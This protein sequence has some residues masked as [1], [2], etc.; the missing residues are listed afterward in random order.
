MPLRYEG[1]DI[2]CEP[3]FCIEKHQVSRVES[4]TWDY[5]HDPT[6]RLFDESGRELVHLQ[7]Y[8]RIHNWQGDEGVNISQEEECATFK[9]FVIKWTKD[10]NGL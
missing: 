10:I 9:E 7:V 5:V 1:R 4:E 6:M 3:H 2:I 8:R